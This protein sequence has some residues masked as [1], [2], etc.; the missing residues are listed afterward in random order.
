MGKSIQ[1]FVTDMDGTLLNKEFSI[2]DAN[3]AALR[4]LEKRG[5]AFAVATGRIYYDAL[6]ICRG[7]SL[8]PY[9]ISNNGACIFDRE[10]RQIFD[11]HLEPGFLKELVGFLEDNGIC[12][13]LSESGRYVARTDWEDMLDQELAEL[14]GRGEEVSR[15]RARFIKEETGRQNGLLLVDDMTEHLEQGEPVYSVSVVSCDRERV[16]K[17]EQMLEGHPDMFLSVS[18]THNGE[19]IRR[20]GTK[21]HALAFLCEYLGIAPQRV[22][23]AGDSLNDM[24]MLKLCGFGIAPENA[25]EEVKQAADYVT[26]RGPEDGVAGAIY[27]ILGKR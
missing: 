2:S 17:V 23:A 8:C 26:G 16:R 5:V 14:A 20:D 19:V 7:Q 1:L 18:G 10:G 4:E 9:I 22:A 25:M 6:T 3:A 12:Y 11:K 13:G 15:Q 24:E 27:H 21:G